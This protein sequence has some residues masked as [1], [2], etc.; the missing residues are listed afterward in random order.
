MV[1][2][3]CN[4]CTKEIFVSFRIHTFFLFPFDAKSELS[5]PKVLR[6]SY[7]ESG[8]LGVLQVFFVVSLNSA[9]WQ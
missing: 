3:K 4:K 8:F 2:M 1:F 9:L 5:K 6:G 7:S